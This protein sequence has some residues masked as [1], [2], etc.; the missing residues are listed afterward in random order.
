MIASF[1]II[2]HPV[3]SAGELF[4]CM[5]NVL[6]VVSMFSVILFCMSPKPG[7]TVCSPCLLDVSVQVLSCVVDS[8]GGLRAAITLTTIVTVDTHV[9]D[10]F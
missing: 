3:D 1:R 8:F 6:R 10:Y 5:V 9:K 4:S 2:V 7:A